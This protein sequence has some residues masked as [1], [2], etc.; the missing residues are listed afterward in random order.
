M[1]ERAS[2]A[3]TDGVADPGAGPSIAVVIPTYRRPDDLARCLEA[4]A[5]QTRAPDQIVVVTRDTDDAAIGRCA[6]L[7]PRL[8]VDVV[9]VERPGLVAALNAGLARVRTSLVAF[10]DDDCRPHPAWIARLRAHFLSDERIGAVGGRDIVHEDGAPS[11]LAARAVGQITW[12]GRLRGN[13]HAISARQ[14][15]QFLKG[16]NMAYRREVLAGFDERLRG[17]GAQV[18]ND[19]KASLEVWSAGHRIIWDPAVIVDHHPAPRAD[20]PRAGQSLA[21]VRKTAHNEVYALM[22][23]RPRRVA[24]VAVS[25][26]FVVGTKTA[27]GILLL[28]YLVLKRSDL[29]PGPHFLATLLGRLEGLA[30]A[31]RSWSS[32]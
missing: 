1:I 3:I 12:F 29:Q 11:T 25:Y 23:L 15:V 17:D 30:T 20:E 26:C 9:T 32:P 2:T 28:P 19:L 27:P 21:S 13:H 14:D 6:E 31:A 10:T 22:S 24:L 16:A 8:P 4:L 18:H 7:S 5:N